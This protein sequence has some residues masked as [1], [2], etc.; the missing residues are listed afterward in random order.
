VYEHP[1]LMEAGKVTE[2]VLGVYG[3]GDDLDGSYTPFPFEFEC[4]P[5]EAGPG[6][7]ALER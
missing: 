5:N 6:S 3:L 4:D 2:V 7:Q 1:V